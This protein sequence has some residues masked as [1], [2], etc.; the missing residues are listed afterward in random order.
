MV[1]R[2]EITKFLNQYFGSILL[3]K[4]KRV[5]PTMANDIQLQGKDK[6]SKLILGVSLSVDFLNEAVKAATDFII[7]HHG[8]KFTDVVY[9]NNS[10]KKRLKILLENDLS[11]A[12]YHFVLDSHPK[13]GNNAVIIKK[14]GGRLIEPIFDDFGWVAELPEPQDVKL[15]S[16]KC[17][18]IFNNDVFA[19][20][21]G[22]AKVKRLAVVSGGGVPYEKPIQEFLAKGVEL[23]IT[24]EVRES[25]PA[26]F[27]EININYFSGGHYATEV[28]GVQEL[29]KI[30]KAEFKDKLEVEFIDV[31]NVL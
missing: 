21:G 5:D 15:L 2:D 24:G 17:S 23:Y 9:L 14:L 22:P 6:V 3:E 4:A 25:R 10:W 26:V 8:L 27:K 7:V 19:V 18:Q 16:K 28:F 30:I 11:L 20:F 13:I 29:G 1:K 31:P 12:G